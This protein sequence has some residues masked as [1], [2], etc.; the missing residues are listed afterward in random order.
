M[1][2][3]FEMVWRTAPEGPGCECVARP[4]PEAQFYSFAS[5][6][7][8]ALSEFGQRALGT[9]LWLAAQARLQSQVFCSDCFW[10]S[11][12][13][14]PGAGRR[15]QDRTDASAGEHQ[16]GQRWYLSSILES[17]RRRFKH[18]WAVSGELKIFTPMYYVVAEKV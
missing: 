1:P 18:V 11:V 14:R 3:Y 15:F 4:L 5:F 9:L 13:G 12:E 7:S 10:L 6:R 8:F 2:W 16:P 17:S